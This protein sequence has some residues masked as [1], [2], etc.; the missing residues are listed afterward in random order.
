MFGL[1]T[2][3]IIS[4]HLVDGQD[5]GLPVARFYRAQDTWFYLHAEDVL[6]IKFDINEYQEIVR[7][8]DY[9]FRYRQD[10][11]FP[12]A[13]LPQFVGWLNQTS[14]FYP[15]WL[16]PLKLDEEFALHP[17]QLAASAP[18]AHSAGLMMNVGIWGPGP[19]RCEALV[20][21][22][23]AIEQKTKELGGL[24]CFYAQAF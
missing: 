11:G 21:A 17:R 19:R 9:L 5:S 14:S 18:D 13:T 22:K 1:H 8:V 7:V 23:R 24:T 20:A 16:R 12:Y 15:L 2:G 6:R 4:G 10:I 3:V